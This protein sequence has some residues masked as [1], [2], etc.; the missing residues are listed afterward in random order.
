MNP[1]NMILRDLGI[2]Q[3]NPSLSYSGTYANM[4]FNLTSALNTNDNAYSGISLGDYFSSFLGTTQTPSYLGHLD[5]QG[6]SPIDDVRPISSPPPPYSEVGSGLTD[7]ESKA[8]STISEETEAVQG[9]EQA[10]EAV[11]GASPAG[12][13]GAISSATTTMINSYGQNERGINIATNYA[14]AMANGHGYSYQD[15]A[16]LTAVAGNSGNS[17]QSTLATGLGALLG[18]VG[19]LIGNALP[20]SMFTPSTGITDVQAS[21]ENAGTVDSGESTQMSYTT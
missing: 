8:I 14:Q 18:P 3:T 17:L 13:I 7:F 4:L 20:S 16:R 2:I 19:A 12:A 9:V 5:A 6:A 10:A 21:Y 11:E 15:N 1:D